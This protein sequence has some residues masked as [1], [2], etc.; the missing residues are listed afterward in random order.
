MRL[1]TPFGS[2]VIYGVN[3]DCKDKSEFCAAGETSLEEQ[4]YSASFYT[5][6]AELLVKSND[7]QSASKRGEPF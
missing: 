1:E 2:I 7:E 3:H 5:C 4:T 6:L